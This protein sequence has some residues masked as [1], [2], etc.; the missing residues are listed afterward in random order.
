MQAEKGRGGSKW[1]FETTGAIDR[2]VAAAILLAVGLV[3]HLLGL[4]AEALRLISSI[5]L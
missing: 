1:S 3:A 5:A 2:A 4:D